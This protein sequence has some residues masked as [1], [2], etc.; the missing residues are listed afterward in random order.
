MSIS[1]MMVH[2]NKQIYFVLLLLINSV[3]TRHDR[4][5]ML[6]NA[7]KDN[8]LSLWIDEQQVKMFSGKLYLPPFL[9][10]SDD[11]ITK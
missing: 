7:D 1:L 4:H 11:I 2:Y 10:C 9:F 3:L 6:H 8:D 5:H